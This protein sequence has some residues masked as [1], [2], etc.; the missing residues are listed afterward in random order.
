MNN[1]ACGD[2]RLINEYIKSTHDFMLN[3]YAVLY[4]EFNLFQKNKRDFVKVAV[5]LTI[6]SIIELFKMK[7]CHAFIYFKKA[8]DSVWHIEQSFI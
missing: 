5:L 2:D 7:L 3:V 8:C 1:K 6:F 4:A